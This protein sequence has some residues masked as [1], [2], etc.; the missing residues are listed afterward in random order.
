MKTT[1]GFPHGEITTQAE[2][3]N[4]DVLEFIR[5]WVPDQPTGG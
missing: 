2:T 1:A 5:S 3:V 4:A